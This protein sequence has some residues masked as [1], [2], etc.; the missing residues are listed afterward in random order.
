MKIFSEKNKNAF[1]KEILELSYRTLNETNVVSG[2]DVLSVP[3]WY[4][5]NVSRNNMFKPYI[6][7]K[8]LIVIGNLLQ[9]GKFLSKEDLELSYG[10]SHINFLIIIN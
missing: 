2:Q 6:Y 4:N 9:E 3:L 10:I 1:W 7:K 5:E 8:G